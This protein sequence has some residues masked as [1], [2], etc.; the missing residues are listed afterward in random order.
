MQ[1]LREKNHSSIFLSFLECV[2]S[3]PLQLKQSNNTVLQ[4]AFY[5]SY[6]GTKHNVW[7]TVGAQ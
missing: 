1:Y 6:P 5:C 3:F 7:I 4:L 2:C